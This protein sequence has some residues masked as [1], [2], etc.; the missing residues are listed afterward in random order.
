MNSYDDIIDLPRYQSKWR[1]PMPLQVR[2]AQF[3]PFAGLPINH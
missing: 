1:K 3:A 2:A